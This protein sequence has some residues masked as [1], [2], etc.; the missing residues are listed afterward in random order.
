MVN[1]LVADLHRKFGQWE[2]ARLI[3]HGLIED[4]PESKIVAPALNNIGVYHHR[5]GDYGTAV[6]YFTEAIRAAPT[7]TEAHYN[8]SQAHTENFSF[9]EA[10][11]ALAQAKRLDSDRVARWDSSEGGAEGNVIPING[12]LRRAEEIQ[13]ALDLAGRESASENIVSRRYLSL[14]ATLAATVLAV[15]LHLL[16]RNKGY[17]SSK[18]TGRPAL[19][20]NRW[21]TG[22][23]PGW[24][25]TVEG[26]GMKAFLAI[27][28]PL[29][30]L[31]V[32][33]LKVWGYC[34]PLGYDAG[35]GLVTI[36]CIVG[37]VILFGI[38]LLVTLRKADYEND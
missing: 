33:M 37:L 28:L 19:E 20:E 29:G 24:A 2:H 15:A 34:A 4:D 7:L 9:T 32:P 21:L 36:L 18:F 12:G 30:L 31:L 17:P 27:L 26:L 10:H 25:S 16:R 3:Y 38:R 14:A 23:Q 8:L 6:N 11:Q 5:K 35:P 22:L 1:E 13:R